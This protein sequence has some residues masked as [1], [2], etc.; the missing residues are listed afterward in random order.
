[1]DRRMTP[2]KKESW[3]AAGRIPAGQACPFRVVCPR[4]S[5]NNCGHF[6]EEHK[7]EFSCAT[8][9][10]F[11]MCWRYG[12]LYQPTGLEA[13]A[14][15]FANRA[16]GAIDQRR[17]YTNEPYIRHPEAVAELVRSVPHTEAMLAAT[18][19]HDVVE[20]TPVTI[21][22]I[23]REFGAEV[24]A[25]VKMLTDVS[26]PQDGNRAV[27]KA[28]DLAHTAKASPAGKTIKLADLIDNSRNILERDPNFARVYLAEKERLLEVLGE[29][30][31]RLLAIARQV[32]ADGLK[33]LEQREST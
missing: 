30:D 7:V 29:G 11:D 8:S 6:G 33:L 28:I 1:M 13:R 25:L 26:R 22:E 3:L 12:W 14:R 24:A 16:H 31:T 20:D 5:A 15:E 27:R 19:L 18:W 10:G 9:R 4:K 2:G 21:E 23:E 17:K 32:L